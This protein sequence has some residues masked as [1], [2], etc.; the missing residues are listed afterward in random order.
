MGEQ[1]EVRCGDIFKALQPS[2][3]GRG[4]GFSVTFAPQET[5]K[6]SGHADGFPQGGFFVGQVGAFVD[7]YVLS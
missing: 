4:A 2:P 1:D 5:S 3:N 7:K 6:G